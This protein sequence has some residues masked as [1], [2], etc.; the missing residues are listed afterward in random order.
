MAFTLLQILLDGSGDEGHHAALKKTGFFGKAGA[1]CIIVARSTGRI[2]MPLRSEDVEQPDTWGTWGGAIDSGEDPKVAAKREVQEEAGY[3]GD[4]DLE[5]LFV[6][7][8]SS[9]FRYYNFL[10]IVQDEFDPVL[11]WETESY[12]WC[13]IE[14]LPSPLHFGLKSVLDDA[15]SM[16]KIMSVVNLGT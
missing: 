12:R 5:D 7:K 3:H 16:K 14:D 1:G 10:A 15:P 11:D 13:D 2:C 8:H 4:L 9:G 6:F